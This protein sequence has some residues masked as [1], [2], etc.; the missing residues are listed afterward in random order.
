MASLTRR[1]GILSATGRTR[2]GEFACAVLSVFRQ[3]FLSRV[4]K[5]FDEFVSNDL[6]FLF[7]V[8]HTFEQSEKALAR[9]DILQTNVKIFAENALHHFFLTRTEQSVVHENASE[10]IADSF[11][12]ERG[13][14]R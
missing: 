11:V 4:L 12:Q 3:Q 5:D 7:G 8:G 2:C 9:V 6:S 14:D 1:A 10:L 13:H